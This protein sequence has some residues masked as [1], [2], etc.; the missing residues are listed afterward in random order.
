L[1]QVGVAASANP[2]RGTRAAPGGSVPSIILVRPAPTIKAPIALP[3]TALSARGG[4]GFARWRTT[5]NRARA[6]HAGQR[7]RVRL[8]VAPCSFFFSARGESKLPRRQ[9]PRS[10]PLTGSTTALG[11]GGHQR[12]AARA[13]ARRA[14]DVAAA[15]SDVAPPPRRAAAERRRP[16]SPAA[17]I[18]RAAPPP[19]PAVDGAPAAGPPPADPQFHRGPAR[20]VSPMMEMDRILLVVLAVRT[21]NVC[22]D[23][24]MSEVQYDWAAPPPP[25]WTVVPQLSPPAAARPRTAS[26][27]G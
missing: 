12:V 3:V 23:G 7:A 18:K 26:R 25:P 1:S 22:T 15:S 16:P 10:P 24:E 27:R 4:S 17:R 21:G 20:Q 9:R 14:A 8:S 19:G 11:G 13:A 2:A 6:D 5:N